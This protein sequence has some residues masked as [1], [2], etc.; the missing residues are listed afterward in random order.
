MTIHM[1]ITIIATLLL[2]SLG[3]AEPPVDRKQD[4]PIRI[5]ESGKKELAEGRSTR[6]R[7]AVKMRRARMLQ[8][9]DANGD[10]KIDEAEQRAIRAAIARRNAGGTPVRTSRS[11]T[12]RKP[13]AGSTATRRIMEFD[14]NGDGVLDARERETAIRTLRSESRSKGRSDTQEADARR[15][16]TRKAATCKSGSDTGESKER[17]RP[18]RPAPSKRTR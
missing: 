8:L 2:A 11:S 3:M 18:V 9:Y 15:K 7:E 6:L 17:I 12:D 13:Q 5:Q 10:G 14:T 16:A 1:T 4:R